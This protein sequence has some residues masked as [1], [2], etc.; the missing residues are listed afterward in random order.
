LTDFTSAQVMIFENV[1]TLFEQSSGVVRPTR[2]LRGGNTQLQGPIDVV[3]D[4][5]EGSEFIYVA[6]RLAKKVFRYHLSSGGNVVPEG[7]ID[8]DGITP[9]GLYLDARGKIF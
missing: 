7:W 9:N 1:S 2:V 6:D 5:R 3:A 4:V 8:F